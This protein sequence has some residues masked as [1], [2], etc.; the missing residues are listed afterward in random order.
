M[1][2]KHYEEMIREAG[3]ID[4]F[5]GG[6][7]PDGHIAFNE[8]G[9]SLRSR[10]RIKTLTSKEIL[11]HKAVIALWVTLWQTNILIHVECNNILKA[12]PLMLLRI[13]TSLLYSVCQLVLHQRACMLSW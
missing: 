11:S 3:G 10:T 4:L 13:K 2:L 9:S 5:L 7:G 6:I 12:Y 8:P 1:W